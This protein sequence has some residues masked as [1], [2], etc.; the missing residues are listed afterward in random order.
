M[1][2]NGIKPYILTIKGYFPKTTGNEVV[3]SLEGLLNSSE[4]VGFTLN[5]IQFEGLTLSKYSFKEQISSVYQ[6]CEITF[7]G[8]ESFST[9]SEESTNE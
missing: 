5:S 6:E 3:L 9:V 2:A 8:V 1:Y 7:M 4:S